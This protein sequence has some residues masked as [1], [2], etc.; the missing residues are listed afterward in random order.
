M[1]KKL[2]AMVMAIGIIAGGVSTTAY[3]ADNDLSQVKA[4]HKAAVQQLK[5]SRGN[6]TSGK[7]SLKAALQN[8]KAQITGENKE[9]NKEKWLQMK[10][11]L[12]TVREERTVIKEEDKALKNDVS[13]LKEQLKA[14]KEGKNVEEAK[15]LLASLIE[16]INKLSANFTKLTTIRNNAVNTVNQWDPSK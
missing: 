4:N 6:F 2:I 12:K 14:A 7:G 5:E 10:D 11:T 16:K 9:I 3:A 8:K 1:V 13:A 15:G